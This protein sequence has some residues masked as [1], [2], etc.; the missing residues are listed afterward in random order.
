MNLLLNARRS[1]TLHQ[2]LEDYKKLRASLKRK[3]EGFHLK[4]AETFSSE[5]INNFLTKASEE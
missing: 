4:K 1:I 5:D 3:S 2:G